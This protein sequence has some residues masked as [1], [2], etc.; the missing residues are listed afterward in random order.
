MR[1][2]WMSEWDGNCFYCWVPTEQMADGRGKGNYPLSSTMTQLNYL[3]EAPSDC[4]PEDPNFVAFVEVT[5]IIGGRNT[6][7]EFVACGL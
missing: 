3:M 1:N 7:E 6:V 2:K 4:G 5:S